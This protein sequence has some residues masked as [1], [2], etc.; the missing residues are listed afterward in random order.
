MGLR[1]EPVF[2][3]VF[4]DPFKPEL[5]FSIEKVRVSRCFRCL[6]SKLLA[7][8]Y[9]LFFGLQQKFHHFSPELVS[10]LVVRKLLVV[11]PRDRS[12]RWIQG[13]F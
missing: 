2:S 4:S 10:S 7:S 8:P 12:T 5:F 6:Q 9:L 1:C 13:F 3:R 11:A